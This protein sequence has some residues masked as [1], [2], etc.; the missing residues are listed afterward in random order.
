MEER[1]LNI[2]RLLTLIG[3]SVALVIL[4]L[5]GIEENLTQDWETYQKNYPDILSQNSPRISGTSMAFY[6]EI[7]QVT[8]EKLNLVDRC[9]SC[10][11][12]IDNPYLRLVPQPYRAH[13]GNNISIHSTEKFGCTTCHRGTGRILE[14]Q[15]ICLQ[16][17]EETIYSQRYIQSAC[18][19][20]HLAIFDENPIHIGAEKLYGG[21]KIFKREGCLG[22][23]KLRQVGGILGPDLTGQGTKIKASYNFRNIRGKI[24]IPNWLKEHF[25]DPE[26]VSPGSAMLK[27][28]LSESD[29]EDL[30]VF[31]LGLYQ[32]E[33]PLEYYSFYHLR[34]FKKRRQITDDTQIFSLFCAACHGKNGEGKSYDRFRTGV[35]ALN[36][37][38][39]QAV[40]SREFLEFTLMKGRSRR[41]MSSWSKEISGLYRQEIEKVI[42]IVRNWRP[43]G[44][45]FIEVQKQPGNLSQG[46]QIYASHCQFCH[47]EK[48]MNGIAP[49]LNNQ[50]FLRIATH[51]FIYQT[52]KTGRSNTAMPAW[53]RFSAPET[54]SLIRLIRSW[55]TQPSIK[56][57]KKAISGDRD[58][59]QD[60]FDHLCIR[61][62]GKHGT[63]GIGPAVMNPDFLRA[64]TDQFLFQT[65]SNGRN[66]TA[67]FGWAK[68]LGKLEKVKTED[69]RNIVTY[70]K[71]QA[72][73]ITDQIYAGESVGRASV[74]RNLY[75]KHCSECH[76][77]D[78]EGKKAPALNNQEFLN[79]ASNGFILATISLGRSETE[80]PS[81]GRGNQKYSKLTGDQRNDI[82]AFVRSWQLQT[83]KKSER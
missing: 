37:Q 58:K 35:P 61:C 48:G 73:S 8:I 76:G 7:R 55:Q 77:Y 10:H 13:P 15:E 63:G 56:H 59:G 18:G 81:W 53:S 45:Q 33:Y 1:F 2:Y 14:V 4:I 70:M 11:L 46:K 29:L 27:F 65:I 72:D 82:V 67:M 75:E 66:H 71:A 34:E 64:A 19:K 3:G 49:V 23:H 60:L 21:L 52:L 26:K 12:G 38:D 32:P 69:I 22:C 9:T 79:A 68:D 78:G 20:C 30:V 36:N 43:V 17:E 50:D 47:G 16:K 41:Q 42:N 25:I 74:G 24:T 28:D 5:M 40:A 62:H 83:I 31:T 51:Q 44:P 80:M 6:N 54:A 39:F 57:S